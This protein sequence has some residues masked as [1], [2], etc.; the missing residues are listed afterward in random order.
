MAHGGKRPGAGRKAGGSDDPRKALV[1]AADRIAAELAIA[2]TGDVK[3]LGKDRLT[4]LDNM[5]MQLVKV[6][7]PKKDDLGNVHWEPGDE[8]RFFRCM[9]MAGKY[10]EARAA[11]ES[12]R[13]AAVAVANQGGEK[14]PDIYTQDPYKVLDD[15]VDRWIAADEAERAEAAAERAER[16]EPEPLTEAE[17]LRLENAE[18]KARLR[19]KARRR[20]TSPEASATPPSEPEVTPPNEIG[21]PEAKKPPGWQKQSWP[22]PQAG[23]LSW[24]PPAPPVKPEDRP[25]ATPPV[26]KSGAE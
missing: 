26:A 18:L 17:Q 5:A 11:F 9:A 2:I 20:I 25:P 7:A 10:A 14:T 3:A 19:G 13:Y 16:G 6:F 1:K 24:L 15:I 8:A 21:D 4:E 22:G 23:T 12:P